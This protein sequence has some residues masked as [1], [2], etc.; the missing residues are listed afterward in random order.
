MAYLDDIGYLD[1]VLKAF[2]DSFRGSLKFKAVADKESYGIGYDGIDIKNIQ[3]FL[4]SNALNNPDW[5]LV[6]D[7]SS[8]TIENSDLTGDLPGYS[9]IFNGE[10]DI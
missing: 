7:S 5:S 4:E 10:F 8:V 9:R 6:I 3:L 2:A 1:N